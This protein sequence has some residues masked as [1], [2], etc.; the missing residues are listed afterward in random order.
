MFTIDEVE[1]SIENS[2]PIGPIFRFSKSDPFEIR[3]RIK[4]GQNEIDKLE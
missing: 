2:A 4:L 3:I 1:F